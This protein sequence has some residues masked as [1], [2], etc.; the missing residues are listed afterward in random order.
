[1]IPLAIALGAE[2]LKLG[3]SLWRE[4]QAKK[5]LEGLGAPP[6]Y[7]IAPEQQQAYEL[8]RSRSRFGF[9]PEET[10]QFRQ[11]M[12]QD[13]STGARNALDVGGGNL[14]RAVSKIG[15]IQKL[16]A[17]GDFAAKDAAMQRQNIHDYYTAAGQMAAQRNRI[18]GGQREDYNRAQQAYGM[19][20][21]QQWQ[22][23][24]GAVSDIGN[25]AA[26]KWGQTPDMPKQPMISS[27]TTM[28]GGG[29]DPN[30]FGM[31]PRTGTSFEPTPYG[32]TQN[33]TTGAA[34]GSPQTSSDYSPM[35]AQL[36]YNNQRFA[37]YAY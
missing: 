4:Y 26:F 5:G 19:A 33:Y 25:A 13:I 9:S 2:G 28:S 10:A 12:A 32:M 24:M 15:T 29:Y 6:Q 14:A 3:S 23:A 31:Y 37:P 27:P 30:R 36:P 21:Q 16:G 22:N 35:P 17:E 20:A 34:Y 11:R 18:T 8:A 1:M 7:S